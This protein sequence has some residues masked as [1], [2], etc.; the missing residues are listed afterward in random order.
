MQKLTFNRLIKH[1]KIV[2]RRRLFDKLKTY[3]TLNQ[4]KKKVRVSL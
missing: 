4:L 2:K 3:I 1:N